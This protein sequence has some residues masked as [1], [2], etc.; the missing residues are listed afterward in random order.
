MLITDGGE[1]AEETALSASELAAWI[2]VT[3]VTVLTVVLSSNMAYATF[4]YSVII[5]L[6]LFIQGITVSFKEITSEET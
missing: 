6:I 5:D 4:E 1:R 2:A 3:P